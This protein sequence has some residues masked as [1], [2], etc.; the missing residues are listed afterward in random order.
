MKPTFTDTL[1]NLM[2]GGAFAF[3]ATSSA[4][5]KAVKTGDES[6]VD[7]RAAK[8]RSD[9]EKS[10]SLQP[11]QIGAPGDAD[12]MWWRNAWHNGGWHNGGWHNGGWHNGGWHNWHNGWHNGGWGNWYNF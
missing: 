12:T 7:L 3:A 9:L 8:V 4:S 10:P 11:G 1:R 6:P 2:L 5:A